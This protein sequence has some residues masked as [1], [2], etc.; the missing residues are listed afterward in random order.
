MANRTA[1]RTGATLLNSPG[2]PHSRAYPENCIRVKRLRRSLWDERFQVAR[3]VV[4]T[5][6]DTREVD[7]WKLFPTKY[8]G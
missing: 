5:Q 4:Y 2:D 1:M 8:I 3:D 7:K 6:K